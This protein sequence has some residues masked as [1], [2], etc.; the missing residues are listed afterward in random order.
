MPGGGV[1]GEISDA[2]NKNEHPFLGLRAAGRPLCCHSSQQIFTIMCEMSNKGKVR[3]CDAKEA[4]LTQGLA[5]HAQCQDLVC[6]LLPES[7]ALLSLS[8]CS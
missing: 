5:G 7:F 1:R 8:K 4:L 2:D 6:I 3:V